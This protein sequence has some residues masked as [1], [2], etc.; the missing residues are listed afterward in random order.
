ML[1]QN[2]YIFSI[3]F[4]IISLIFRKFVCEFLFLIVSRIICHII[5]NKSGQTLNDDLSF[6]RYINKIY[7]IYTLLSLFLCVNIFH[8][9][10]NR[11]LIWNKQNMIMCGRVASYHHRA[12]CLWN[13]AAHTCHSSSDRRHLGWTPPCLLWAVCQQPCIP[14]LQRFGHD[15][16]TGLLSDLS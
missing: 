15:R 7:T 3:L 16:A 5:Y 12:S 1:L 9:T 11:F 4:I 8:V 2:Y 13:S 6:R 10:L 14:W